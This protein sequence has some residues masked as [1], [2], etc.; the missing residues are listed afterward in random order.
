MTINQESFDF[1]KS[2]GEELYKS[3]K[4]VKC[5]YFNDLVYFNWQGLRHLKFKGDRSER[6]PQ[7]QR[8]RFKLLYLAP[9]L[10]KLTRT[11]QGVCVR[12]GFE[13]VRR[14]SKTQIIAVERKYYEFIAV[15]DGVRIRVIV[16]QVD[17]GDLLFWS[18][19]PYWSFDG[20]D[21][22]IAFGNSEED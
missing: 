14:N 10:L 12:K 7:D 15:L 20:A 4:P 18:I 2:R 5:P 19:I 13:R 8:M 3:F 6:L 9:T 11:V 21:R 16:K 1:I 17:T 22:V